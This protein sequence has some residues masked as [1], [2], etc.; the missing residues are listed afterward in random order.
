MKKISLIIMFFMSSNLMMAQIIISKDDM[1]SVNDNITRFNA[2]NTPGI[3]FE[4]TGANFNWNFTE[5]LKTDSINTNCFSL[6]SA[7]LLYI[8]F[9]PSTSYVQNGRFQV[10]NIPLL[11]ITISNV[12]DFMRKTDNTFSQLGSGAEI[13]GFPT[14]IVYS[15]ADIIYRFPLSFGNIDSSNSTFDINIPTLGSW[16]Q[17]KKRINTVDGYGTIALPL[18]TFYNVVRVKSELFLTDSIAAEISGFPLNFGIN[19][20]Q[21][22][23]KWLANN[24]D[25][26][27]LQINTA[28]VFGSEAIQSI[29]FKYAENT[30]NINEQKENKIKIYPNPSSNEINISGIMKD[31]FI[32]DNLGKLVFYINGQLGNNI[33]VDV[34]NWNN[35]LYIAVSENNKI[36]F[37][38]LH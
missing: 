30:N 20:R 6:S 15:P 4:Q 36:R 19:S 18:D 37:T 33:N 35:G 23:Y 16:R 34:E 28:I 5:L 21:I 27:V 12:V 13:S 1:P 29:A 8:P 24:Q 10:P 3:N 9:F 14:P 2:Q 25:L 38:V 31:I 32:Y 17:W 22:E 11:P 7:G 26:P